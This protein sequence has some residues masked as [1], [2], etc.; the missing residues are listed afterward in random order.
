MVGVL[1]KENSW[2]DKG[3]IED[4]KKAKHYIDF[5]IEKESKA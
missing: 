5:L 1:G 2:R 3:G 4:L